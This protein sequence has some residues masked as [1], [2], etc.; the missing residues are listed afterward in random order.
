MK[1]VYIAIYTANKDDIVNYNLMYFL[2]FF[3]YRILTSIGALN[4]ESSHI[5]LVGIFSYKYA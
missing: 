5:S 4:S 3:I 1:A 2:I